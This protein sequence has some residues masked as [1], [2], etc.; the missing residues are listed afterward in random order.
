MPPRCASGLSVLFADFPLCPVLE[1]ILKDF[2]LCLFRQE[3][4]G[5]GKFP[6]IENNRLPT[7]GKRVFLA[8]LRLNKITICGTEWNKLLAHQIIK[9]DFLSPL[10]FQP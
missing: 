5:G 4:E 8:R 6:V 10:F 7:S 9:G 2:F 1:V 3:G